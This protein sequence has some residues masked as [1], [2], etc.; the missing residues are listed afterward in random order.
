L[1]GPTKI[2]PIEISKMILDAANELDVIVR[3]ISVKSKNAT[4]IGRFKSINLL[5]ISNLPFNKN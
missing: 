5:L 2:D 1:D 3:E 4:F